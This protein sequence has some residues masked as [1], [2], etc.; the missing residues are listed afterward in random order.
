MKKFIIIAL[1]LI[2]VA[3][4]VYFYKNKS[5]DGESGVMA[6]ISSALGGSSNSA[7]LDYVPADTVLFGGNLEPMDYEKAMELTRNMGFD[8]NAF[9]A[10]ADEQDLQTDA[11]APD[12]AKFA[13]GFYREYLK[14][15]ASDL[16]KSMG[17]DKNL[18]AAIYTVGA[19]PV[20]R[21]ALDG[22]S[23]FSD[24][25]AKV[26][27]ENNVT[28]KVGNI[29]GQEYREY[30]L[31]D[32][33]PVTLIIATQDNQAVVTIN[34][35]LE[36][37]KDLKLALGLEKPAQSIKDSKLLSGLMSKY[38]YEGHNIFFVDNLGAVKG[39]T[40]PT[41]NSFGSMLN[42]LLAAYGDANALSELQT[43]ACKAEYTALAGNWP[44][45]SAGYT[46][47]N[48]KSAK[49]KMMLE[50]TNAGLLETLQKLQGHLSPML[51]DKDFVFSMGMGLNMAELTPVVTDLWKRMTKEP[52]NCEPLAQMQAEMKRSN[53]VMQLGM[54][55][56][57]FGGVKGFGFA[58]VDMDIDGLS[59]A[60]NNPMAVADSMS[61]FVTLSAD[62]PMSLVQMV[63]QFQPMLA[64]IKLEDGGEPQNLPLP[65]PVE[66]KG[67][68]RGHDL[69]LSFGEKAN[70][71]AGALKSNSSLDMNGLMSFSIDMGK[72]FGM[73]DQAMGMA[74]PQG[75]IDGLSS[76]DKKALEM[77]KN[78][79]GQV[80][81]KINFTDQGLAIDVDMMVD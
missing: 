23:T 81:E 64:N 55:T 47:I 9:M 44:T 65:L 39:V 59:Q 67:T 10:L 69:V 57:M 32:Q 66:V 31:G 13:L 3:V 45:L 43:P 27:K 28:A 36:D 71:M 20:M 37:A 78:I 16:P 54:M 35:L 70:A 17:F 25:I 42:D 6:N 50:G 62:D 33:A 22:S 14:A 40:D 51:D 26:E 11:D 49:Y 5:A 19:L 41:A 56:G 58:V 2:A 1:A 15:L 73:I 46:E 72:Y 4:G 79:K 76:G 53:P 34:T 21:M 24:L 74:E 18:D 77:F 80:S 61:M 30:S 75:G 48:A 52:F 7:V 8:F 29:D 63:G 12:A 60:Q 38:G 68:L